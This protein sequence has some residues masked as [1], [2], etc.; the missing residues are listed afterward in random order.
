MS[1]C[2]R[3]LETVP[4]SRPMDEW[5]ILCLLP[6][7][8][9][10]VSLRSLLCF[11]LYVFSSGLRDNYLRFFVRLG[12]EKRL[13]SSTNSDWWASSEIGF[14]SSSQALHGASSLD[15][16]HQAVGSANKQSWYRLGLV[17]IL[18]SYGIRKRL[19]AEIRV[20]WITSPLLPA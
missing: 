18:A 7:R 11:T 2:P 17:D 1:F 8:L 15:G 13:T 14:F 10:A 6:L 5:T 12:D 3:L 4:G 19:E 9:I 20:R 16:S